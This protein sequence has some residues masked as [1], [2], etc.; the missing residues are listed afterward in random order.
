MRR[1]LAVFIVSSLTLA[2]SVSAQ[3]PATITLRSGERLT[4]RLVTFDGNQYVL[5]L[6]LAVR[7]IAAPDVIAVEL[8]DSRGLTDGQDRQLRQGRPFVL[9]RNGQLVEGRLTE[10]GGRSG[11]VMVDTPRG[12]RAFDLAQVAGIY[13]AS[14]DGGFGRNR[15]G[16]DPQAFGDGNSSNRDGQGGNRDGQS[17]GNQGGQNSGNANRGN[18]NDAGSRNGQ[19][20]GGQNGAGRSGSVAA[21]PVNTTVTIRGNE[22]WK[23]TGVTVQAGDAVRFQAS[24][25][26]R[27]SPDPADNAAPQGAANRHTVAG[28]PLPQQ[29]GGALLGRVGDGQP[30]LIGNQSSVTMGTSGL[31]LLG[32]ND[33]NVADNSGEFSV[34]IT[35]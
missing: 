11:R 9:L 2:A 13:M 19:N 20:A 27:F 4:G 10:F 33:D 31:L 22:Q 17:P 21:A 24:G 14:P 8:A 32:I 6:G 23:S 7:Q 34:V 12:A 26:V 15:N 5:R 29:P 25:N 30:F 16:R 28:A 1:I 18:A 3:T 35:K